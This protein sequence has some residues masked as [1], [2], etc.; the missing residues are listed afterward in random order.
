[1]GSIT[2][3]NNL[4]ITEDSLTPSPLR[5]VEMH[6]D[7]TTVEGQT[8]EP[9]IEL[10]G[11]VDL[12]AGGD[13]SIN[14]KLTAFG[15]GTR[16][17][18]IDTT[19]GTVSIAD[20]GV[21]LD[22]SQYDVGVVRADNV[23][24]GGGANDDVGGLN[25]LSISGITDSVNFTSTSGLELHG[26]LS[27][28]SPNVNIGSGSTVETFGDLTINSTNKVSL[29]GDVRTYNSGNI[30]INSPDISLG[31]DVIADSF[32]G[33]TLT[34]NG[35]ASVTESI[36]LGSGG[37]LTVTGALLAT[38]NATH[39]IAI[40]SFS[41]AK[42]GG[43]VGSGNP[44]SGLA[45][46]NLTTDE[47]GTTEFSANIAAAYQTFNDDL[48]FT[49]SLTASGLDVTFDGTVDADD[50]SIVLDF[51]NTAKIDGSSW[52]NL[53]AL[54]VNAGTIG[55][56][57]TIESSGSQ[58][59][60]GAV[61]LNM[62][63]SA[64][65]VALRGFS[66]TIPG[67]INGPDNDY[68]N[69]LIDF[70][71]TTAPTSLFGFN[72]ISNFVSE[73]DVSLD[74]T[75]TNDGTQ[76]FNG[77]V[78]LAGDTVLSS[79][80]G[81]GAVVW[82]GVDGNSNDLS[83]NFATVTAIDSTYQNLKNLTVN[84]DASLTGTISTSGFQDYNGT[85]TLLGNTA[86]SA[87]SNVRFGDTLDGSHDLS[88]EADS[89][90]IDFFGAL[91]SS[92]PLRSLN[93]ESAT[94]VEALAPLTID[95]AGGS[96]PGLRVG[97]NVD[98]ININTTSD[99]VI[100]NASQDGILF[101]GGSANS[102]LGNFSIENSGGSGVV[103]LA[104]N[105][106]GSTFAN[107]T[108]GGSGESGLVTV[109]A[110]G[111]TVNNNTFV[112]NANHGIRFDAAKNSVAQNNVVGNNGLY[113]VLVVTSDEFGS[114]SNISVDNNFIGMNGSG[115]D[116]I[117]PNGR[118]GIWI[119]GNAPGHG[120]VDTVSITG[121]TIANNAVHG[122]EVWGA[123]NVHIGGRR[124]DPSENTITNNAQ[125]GI[126]FTDTVTGSKV[127]GNTLVGNAEAGLFLNNAQG[128]QV[129]G[130][131]DGASS[132]DIS[133]S[134]FG[135]V[136]GG[137]LSNT[138]VIGNTIHE[139]VRAG[140]QL[141]S[142]TNFQI[143]R[144]T[145][146][147]NGA[148]GVL[149]L[150][151][152]DGSRVYGNTISRHEAGV[153]LAGA[154]GMTIGSLNGSSSGPLIGNRIEENSSVGIIIQGEDSFNNVILSNQIDTNIYFGIQFVQGA[155]T[156][157][158]PRL[159]S[160]TTSQVTGVILGDEGDVYRI[161]FFYTPLAQAEDG[162]HAQGEYLLGYEDVT[163]GSDG[164]ATVEL[165]VSSSQMVAGDIVTATATS[166]VDGSPTQSSSFSQGRRAREALGNTP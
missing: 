1:L 138:H 53:A 48:V 56:A 43:V 31:A 6:G 29:G 76:T 37:D 105:Y 77:N 62:D 107:S 59:Y 85:T 38:A 10:R 139:N 3:V 88:I 73:S 166:M 135:V 84:S 151:E 14:G 86:L 126:A 8:Y 109:N 152:S 54:T 120:T 150:G 134:D 90:R 27:V 159:T 136:A 19:S 96:G 46:R 58:T 87:T 75:F 100:R 32:S 24:L 65:D 153:W 18:D 64:G 83:L 129:G 81:V 114:T 165:D 26:N 91:G 116:D 89:G 28:V 20:F 111:F 132:L 99:S 103:A 41:T 4:A 127:T 143:F 147:E 52:S 149:A 40:N 141:L 144:N 80:S 117:A 128:M 44:A 155:T 35:T 63:D 67:A 50:S 115:S 21:S 122:I 123:T 157:A 71:D 60:N 154:S 98:N 5:K 125:Y 163:I 130:G 55:L 72:K 106:T 108:V 137:D 118:S 33:G 119:L 30:A 94:A 79:E 39:D 133:E 102:T 162:R 15:L 51:T 61:Q 69:F 78:S 161:Q 142:A 45:F 156:V 145:I 146:E 160:V 121:N 93:L 97:P 158:V 49:N 12:I 140:F 148:Y 112:A 13:V 92:A 34:L 47:F 104:G 164:A 95:G 42:I 17:L 70:E 74:G 2:N 68:P 57:G 23:D 9:T 113:G 66:L 22:E 110:D 36:I 82:N 16:S 7:V 25:N 131:V 11:D 101:Y 124:G